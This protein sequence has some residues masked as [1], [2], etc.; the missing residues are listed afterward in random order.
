[1]FPSKVGNICVHPHR[2]SKNRRKHACVTAS[3]SEYMRKRVC[4]KN[5]CF[6]IPPNT[7]VDVFK[8]FHNQNKIDVVEYTCMTNMYMPA[9]TTAK[10]NMVIFLP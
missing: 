3:E 7:L 9:W 5:I 2:N 1:M 4:V 6:V 10:G 8:T